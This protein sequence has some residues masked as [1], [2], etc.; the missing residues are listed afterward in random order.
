MYESKR[1]LIQSLGKLNKYTLKINGSTLDIYVKCNWETNSQR[2]YGYV[3]RP[4][5][6]SE[7]RCKKVKGRKPRIL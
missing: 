3:R 4:V 1:G 2:S 5:R 6:F 7:K